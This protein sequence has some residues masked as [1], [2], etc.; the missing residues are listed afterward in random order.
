M[1]ETAQDTG[2]AG[3]YRMTTAQF[4]F[5]VLGLLLTPGPTNTL[6]AL[7]GAESGFRRSLVLVPAEVFAYLSVVI[8]LATIGRDLLENWPAASSAIKL[9]AAAWI[10]LLAVRLWSPVQADTPQRAV[11]VRR[12]LAT[13]LLN[14]KGLV[15]GL[16]LL[17]SWSSPF[18]LRHVALFCAAIVLVSVTWI[19]AGSGITRAFSS[20]RGLRLARRAAAC[21]LATLSVVLVAG[22]FAA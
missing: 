22:T 7:S 1:P 5:A 14:P 10:M 6:L 12:V 21:W 19:V 9:V 18:F 2:F 3:Q 11:T 4:L 20:G 17:P 15:F 16:V 8:P 13:T